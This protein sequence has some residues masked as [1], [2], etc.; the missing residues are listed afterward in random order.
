APSVST[1]RR[2]NVRRGMIIGPVLL[3][4]L[5]L[6]WT[7]SGSKTSES[8]THLTKA[9]RGAISGSLH[10]LGSIEALIETPVLSPF[11]GEV[12]WK[13]E[14]G[15]FVEAGEPVVRLDSS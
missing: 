11:N 1:R 6:I 3:A 10:E 15:T 7:V 13:I 9:E 14:D 5:G 8:G 2:A 4:C 12:V